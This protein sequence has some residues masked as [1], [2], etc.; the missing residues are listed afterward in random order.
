[1]GGSGSTRWGLSVTR[2]TTERLPQLDVRVLARKGA[3]RPG[4]MSTVIWG[5][6]ATIKLSVLAGDANEV[7]LAYEVPTRRDGLIPIR[8]RIELT[9]TPCTFGGSRAWFACPGCRVRCAVL[10]ALGG[11]FR[12]RWC[13]HIAYASTRATG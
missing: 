13:H 9:R 8:E 10:Y 5:D 1:M 11:C 6:K 12:C 2:V 7:R 4:A 3:L